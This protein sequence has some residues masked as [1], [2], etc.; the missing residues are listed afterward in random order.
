MDG[1]DCWGY[2]DTGMLEAALA[3]RAAG[4]GGGHFSGRPPKLVQGRMRSIIDPQDLTALERLYMWGSGLQIL[5]DHPWT[6]VGIGGVKRVYAGYKHPQAVR[7][8][9]THLHNNPMQVAA[10]RGLM[11]LGCWL[12]IWGAF[13][14]YAI[15]IYRGLTPDEF[16][17][18]ALVIA[19]LACVT[20]FHVAG[21]TEYTF[22]DSEVVM[23]VYFL[24]ALPFIAQRVGLAW[25]SFEGGGETVVRVSRGTGHA[26]HALEGGSR[27]TGRPCY[28][29]GLDGQGMVHEV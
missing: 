12:W 26:R 13:Y 14:W 15:R 10:E 21:L 25:R 29:H 16:G 9:R 18:K 20:G 22:G 7:D 28:R 3:V 24:M 27:R 5:R 2:L 6:G 11:G 1:V 17:A 8:Q 19:S 23:L 4:G